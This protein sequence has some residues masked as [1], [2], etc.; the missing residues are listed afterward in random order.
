[1]GTR[2]GLKDYQREAFAKCEALGLRP[3]VDPLHDDHHTDR[4]LT[5][6]DQE[7]GDALAYFLGTL[8]SDVDERYFYH[9]RTSV[10]EWSRIARALRIHGLKICTI[11][12][13]Q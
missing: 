2:S 6:A 4:P 12:L 10:D 11:N 3:L 7:I 1:M 13:E 9:E 8:F 5:S